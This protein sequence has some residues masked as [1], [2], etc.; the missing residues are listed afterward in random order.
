V[1]PA[2]TEEKDFRQ[3]LGD[4]T[5]CECGI[6][7]LSHACALEERREITVRPSSQCVLDKNSS[8]LTR[9]DG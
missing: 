7:S 6:N 5:K 8:H 2:K 4:F 1:Q 3:S 9:L